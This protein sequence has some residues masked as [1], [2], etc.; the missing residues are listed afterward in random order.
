LRPKYNDRILDV[1]YKT[2]VVIVMQIDVALVYIIEIENLTV[3][4]PRLLVKKTV[5]LVLK[6]IIGS[7][8]LRLI[9]K[10]E[11]LSFQVFRGSFIGGC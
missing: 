7:V 6:P 9:I 10:T 4:L 3:N 5:F 1:I 2:L 11:S 8:E